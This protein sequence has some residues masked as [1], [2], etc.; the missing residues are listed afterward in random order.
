[1]PQLSACC[2]TLKEVQIDSKFNALTFKI[3]SLNHQY[4][5]AYST[6]GNEFE[7]LYT[8]KANL[9]L[10]RKYTGANLAVYASGNGKNT[11]EKAVFDWVI[12]KGYQK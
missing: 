1:M 4:R 10:S 9:V 2:S 3:E 12:Y 11:K 6:D 8:S 5:Y 7:W